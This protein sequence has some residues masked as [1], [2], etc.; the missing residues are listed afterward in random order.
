MRAWKSRGAWALSVVA[1]CAALYLAVS[2]FL[3]WR[4]AGVAGRLADSGVVT[5]AH[6]AEIDT[7]TYRRPTD[8]NPSHSRPV[9][10]VSAVV[11]LPAGT[12]RVALTGEKLHDAA[13]AVDP[14]LL[15][16]YQGTFEVVY[17]PAAPGTVMAR[18]DVE[19]LAGSTSY[20]WYAAGVAACLAT[21]LAL[22]LL[23]RAL[24]GPGRE[25]PPPLPGPSEFSPSDQRTATPE[26]ARRDLQVM[27]RKS[28]LFGRR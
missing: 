23:S 9:D 28:G 2:G 13:G 18:P 26:Q 1:L 17:D 10:R 27:L 22:R 3:A 15:A 11:D 12:E 8:V 19:R 5:T 4:E 16:H 6:D 24:R 14:A 20:V 7:S 21:A 25:G